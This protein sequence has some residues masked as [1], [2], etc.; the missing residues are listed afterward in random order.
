MALQSIVAGTRILA[1][2]PPVDRA[3]L[4][5]HGIPQL[6]CTGLLVVRGPGR[7]SVGVSCPRKQWSCP[8]RAE[9][10]LKSRALGFVSPGAGWIL[11]SITATVGF[12]LSVFL[13]AAIPTLLAMRVAALRT[14]A[15]MARL[16]AEIPETAAVMRL[17]GLELADA[18]QEVTLLSQD[19]TAGVQSSA[20][21][22][23]AAEQGLKQG[24]SWV[25]A[26]VTQLLL[27]E[28]KSRTPAV[29]AAADAIQEVVRIR[30]QRSA[31]QPD[32]KEVLQSITAS[33]RMV[34]QTRAVLVAARIV[35]YGR[36][37]HLPKATSLNT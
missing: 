2:D 19:V 21:A 24:A 33:K 35:K 22:V 37:E 18:I 10:S 25:Q 17:S 1:V 30:A 11:A 29:R 20:R 8:R 28:V 32:L 9:S 12:F 6:L 36:Q 31:A 34:Q 4:S 7:S 16:E 14:A 5:S 3:R 23:T 27:P 26:A 13:V 15:V